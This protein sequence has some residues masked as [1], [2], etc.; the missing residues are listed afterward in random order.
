MMESIGAQVGPL[1]ALGDGSMVGMVR[2]VGDVYLIKLKVPGNAAGGLEAVK[3]AERVG[4]GGDPYMYT[5]FTGA[6]LYLTN[7][8]NEFDFT[9]LGTFDAKSPVRQLGFTWTQ[10]DGTSEEFK[11]IKVDV[12]CFSDEANKGEFQT[13]EITAKPKS[14]QYLGVAS[15]VDKLVTKAELRM[16]QMGTTSTS[17]MGVKVVQLTA[18]Q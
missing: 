4:N 8:L 14:V 7:T 17:L 15:C 13:V 1:S 3:I 5:D 10:V 9:K 11:D 12:R 2:G 6:T 18:F 16:T